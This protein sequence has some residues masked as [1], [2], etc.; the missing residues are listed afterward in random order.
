M[1]VSGPAGV[2]QEREPALSG[3]Q[4]R[5]VRYFVLGLLLLVATA[6]VWPILGRGLSGIHFM[7]H[8]T[9]YL[10]NSTLITTHLVADLLIGLSYVVISCT[11]VYL[12][13]ASKG[14]IPFHWMFLAFGTFIIACGGTHF[15][16]AITLWHPIY[17]TSAYVK[18]IT[19]VA[20]VATAIA[21]P[22]A[23]PN[24]L[25]NVDAVR[26]SAV[27]ELQLTKANEELS[28]ANERLQELDQLRRRF[29]AQASADFGDWE[30]DIPSGRVRWS[31]EVERMNGLAR[32]TFGGTYEAWKQSVHP[33]DR[34]RASATALAAV[35]NHTEYDTEYRALRPDGNISW[36]AVRGMAEYDSSGQ[37]LRMV[38]MCVD[39]TKRKLTEQALR[40]SE[41][42]AAA[43]RLAATIAHE[44]NNPLEAVTNLLYLAR[45]DGTAE[46]YKELLELA[47]RELQ[48]VSHITHQTLGFYRQSTSPG[49]VDV[50]EILTGILDIFRG[51]LNSRGDQDLHR[52]RFSGPHFGCF[53]RAAPG[54]LQPAQQR[55]RCLSGEIDH[56]HSHQAEQ[57][58]RA[59]H[60]R[61]PGTSNSSGR[62]KRRS[63]NHS[64]PPRRM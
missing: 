33:E 58:V 43:G 53:G 38:G 37:P 21:L 28:A 13:R 41:K 7:P 3:S 52:R 26:V 24:V 32:G 11:L 36:L 61:R 31:P 20:S 49:M 59:G 27:R 15:M 23:L 55:H 48:R 6:L 62:R 2:S 16:E 35:S 25:K 18:V 39:I 47:D 45:S 9:C 14:G 8:V 54:F 4:S 64:S 19:A 12:V 5:Q 42:L 57:P 56:S 60:H 63:S 40:K 46:N 51:K 30:W 17:W 10:G 44:I 22:I 29:V 50:V 34:E 1:S